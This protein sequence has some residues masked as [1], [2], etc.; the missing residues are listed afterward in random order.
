MTVG[1]MIA[2]ALARR[3]GRPLA[4]RFAGAEELSELEDTASTHGTWLV[5]LTRPLPV[6]AEAG[7]L[8][9]GT[10]RSLANL[11]ADAR[12]QQFCDRRHLC[13]PRLLRQ[14]TR[15]ASDR[16]VCGDGI[17]RRSDDLARRS[18]SVRSR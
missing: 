13:D 1:G 4:E 10:L 16:R 6:L 5:L 18:L 7:V 14:R 17:A 15:L 12:D 11:L 2:F 9:V 3:W 8:L